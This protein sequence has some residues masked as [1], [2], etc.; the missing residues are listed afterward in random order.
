MRAW[1]T[2]AARMAGLEEKDIIS[3][4]VNFRRFFPHTGFREHQRVPLWHPKVPFV[5]LTSQKAGSTLGVGWFLHHAG[6]LD[7]ARQ[8]HEFVHRYEQEVFLRSPSYFEGLQEAV[9][10]RPVLKLVREPGARAFSSYLALHATEVHVAKNDHRQ[11]LRRRIAQHA[12]LIDGSEGKISFGAFL[13]WVAA[14]DH[15]RLDGHEARQVNQYED[16]LPLGL[17]EPIK[18]EEAVNVLPRIE[19]RF[20]LVR[21]S[22]T[23][24]EAFGASTHYVPKRGGSAMVETIVKI[25]LDLPRPKDIPSIT[26]KMLAPYPRAHEHLLTAYGEDFRRYDYPTYRR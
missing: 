24:L 18:L 22:A 10:T 8:H 11:A 4:S 5:L 6:L 17:P 23:Q 25:G 3:L 19:D 9:A 16:R 21:S 20:G 1:T 12:Q 14:S 13:S 2:K 15:K 7:E 26:T